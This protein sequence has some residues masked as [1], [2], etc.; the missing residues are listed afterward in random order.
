MTN[1]SMNKLLFILWLIAAGT[2][3]LGWLT[4]GFEY[5]KLMICLLEC[6]LAQ[7]NYREYKRT[8]K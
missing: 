2:N 7:W 4:M 6:L 5:D 1:K 3:L 8:D